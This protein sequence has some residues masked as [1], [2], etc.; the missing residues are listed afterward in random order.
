MFKNILIPTDG[1]ALSRS[2]IAAGVKLAKAVGAKV[3]AVYAA[4]PATPLVYKDLLPVGYMTPDKH[5]AAIKK[6]VENFLS[7][8]ER[9]AKAAGVRCKTLHVTSDFPA[10]V[11]LATAA[12]EK[13]D[14]IFIASHG[15]RGLTRLLLGSQTQKVLAGSKVPVLVHR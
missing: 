3:T 13:C 4:P 14:L 9:K 7:L 11:I 6:A 12:K 5:A 15:R 8:V 10:E 2:A 1:S